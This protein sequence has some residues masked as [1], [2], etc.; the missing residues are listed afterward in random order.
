[1]GQIKT[2]ELKSHKCH[3]AG[4]TAAK[5]KGAI[6]TW[7]IIALLTVSTELYRKAGFA[8]AKFVGRLS[9]A[10]AVS[11]GT[12]WVAFNVAVVNAEV[13]VIFAIRKALRA[14]N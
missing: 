12:T 6:E 9:R 3:A 2:T 4:G 10:E 14:A 13:G 5:A 1:M 11:Y 8:A 7:G